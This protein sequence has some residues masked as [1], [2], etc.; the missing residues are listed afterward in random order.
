MKYR[1]Y[2]I[3]ALAAVLTGLA[4]QWP[5]AAGEQTPFK[6]RSA[7]I[8]TNAGFDPVL[9]I[10][11]L[12]QS[13]QGVA[14]HLGRFTVDGTTEISV[15]TGAVENNLVLTAS[16]GDLLLLKGVDG[17]GT[18]PNT[19]SGTLNILGGTGKFQGATGVLHLSITFEIAPPTSEP[20]PYT[21]VLEGTISLNQ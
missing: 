8:I 4:I 6:A 17:T 21:E 13:G 12:H 5:V 20:N 16:N 14:T 15:A 1:L 7:G 19:A 18:G 10:V 3:S 2:T 11:Y 9:G